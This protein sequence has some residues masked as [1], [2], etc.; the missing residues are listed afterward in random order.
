MSLPAGPGGPALLHAIRLGLQPQEFLLQCHRRYGDAFTIRIPGRPTQVV[1]SHPDAVKAIFTGSEDTLRAGEAN[2]ILEPVLGT[3]SLLLLDG[4]QHLRERR[5]MLPPFHGERMQA[6]GEAMRDITDAAIDR[7]PIGRAFPLHEEMQSITLDVILRTVFGMEDGAQL[8][9]LRASLLRL[10][11]VATS[12]LLLMTFLRR[13]LG[14]LTPWRRFV[15]LR[16]E[17]D[18]LLYAELARR[19]TTGTAERTDILSMLM[20]ARDEQGNPMTDVELRDEMITLLLAGH[21]TT[22][23][24]LAWAVCR[25][26]EHPDVLA[27]LQAERAVVC[28]DGPVTAEHVGA[29]TWC[30]ATVKEA[31]RL[32]PII[33][34]VGRILRAPMQI[35]GWDLPAG[36]MAAPCIFLTHHRADVWPDP[37][38]FDP[39]RFLD[40]KPG[41]YA[42]FPFGGGVRRC[43]GMAFAMF[44]MKVVLAQ[45]LGRL[46]LRLVPG[47]RAEIVRRSITLAPSKGMPVIVERRAA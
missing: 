36:T 8:G 12:P 27:R 45:V 2:V 28:G 19:R 34:F 6:Y 41:P 33:Q 7:W 44:E 32:T 9:A 43:I 20:E 47:Y 42:F 14:P 17:V 1:F 38:R 22:A 26:L 16:A 3:H 15:A 25:I 46:T 29:L 10:L 39:A 4:A 40:A 24:T 30:D 31:L 13:D 5:L 37:E 21:E 23:T 18:A 11:A 35:G